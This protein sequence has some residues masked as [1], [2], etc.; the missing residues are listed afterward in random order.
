[1]RKAF[2]LIELIVVIGIIAILATIVIVA[3][4]P[5]RQLAQG[6]NTKRKSDLNSLQ[7]ALSQYS[8]DNLGSFP[9]G[10][11]GATKTIGTSVGDSYVDLTSALVPQY[12]SAVPT[13]PSDGSNADTKYMVHL[14]GTQPVLTASAAELNENIV[15]G[16]QKNY[17]LQFDGVNDCVTLP[18]AA[19][20]P[21]GA[22]F[23]Y[24][25][26]VKMDGP[27]E[28]YDSIMGIGGNVWDMRLYATT[29][30]NMTAHANNTVVYGIE[31]SG[32]NLGDGA[33]HHI[34][35][36]YNAD[37]N[38]IRGFV[39]GILRGGTVIATGATPTGVT[40]STAWDIGCEDGI[41]FV[42]ATIDDV[43]FSNIARYSTNF[44]PPTTL[45][46]DSNTLALF[47]FNEGSGTTSKDNSGKNITATLNNGPIWVTR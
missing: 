12:L 17:A 43:R 26:L 35:I 24:E 3:V 44:T 1:M 45:S 19:A 6:R 25:T 42:Q 4:N 38:Y 36:V 27:N 5:A 22:Q 9:S 28:N 39:D 46:N 8:A 33:W 20:M 31:L 29:L 7:K 15:I 30:T 13:D 40:A 37:G 16:G 10:V 18:A 41:R 23:T 34:A 2:T 47:R 21:S 11:T 14:E 32:F